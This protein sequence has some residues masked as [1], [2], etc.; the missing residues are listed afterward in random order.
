MNTIT[1]LPIFALALV[2]LAASALFGGTS[3]TAVAG[4]FSFGSMSDED[5][6]QWAPVAADE[7]GAALRKA[8]RDGEL[9][10]STAE[11]WADQLQ[12]VADG[13]QPVPPNLADWLGVKG[14]GSFALEIAVIELDSKLREGGSWGDAGKAAARAKVVAGLLAA[15]FGA[16]AQSPPGPSGAGL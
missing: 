16:I 12:G 14:W 8:Q 6:A 11:L 2:S 1:N 10:A 15:Q 4:L 9:T 7:V 13:S 5:F 3:C